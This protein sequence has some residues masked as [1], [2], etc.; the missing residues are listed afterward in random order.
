MR[1]LLPTLLLGGCATIKTPTVVVIPKATMVEPMIRETPTS[2]TTM[3]YVI[4]GVCIACIAADLLMV[5]YDRFRSP[6]RAQTH[7]VKE[8]LNQ[9]ELVPQA[10]A[11]VDQNLQGAKD[12]G[13]LA[14][15]PR[16][17]TQ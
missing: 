12:E 4:V 14:V 2:L 13:V 16:E 7:D 15:T 6:P 17:K 10:N 5:A 9:G 11:N 3:M 1:H 8:H